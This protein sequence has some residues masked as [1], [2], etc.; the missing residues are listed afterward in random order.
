MVIVIRFWCKAGMFVF[1]LICS[2]AGT[3]E[4]T[5]VVSDEP[6]M[7]VLETTPCKKFSSKVVPAV[8]A[9]P[10]GWKCTSTARRMIKRDHEREASRNPPVE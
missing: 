7:T 6:V 2:S 3:N 8:W 9:S 10:C 1:S 5:A 4:S